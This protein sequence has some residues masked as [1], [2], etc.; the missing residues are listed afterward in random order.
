MQTGASIKELY[1]PLVHSH[2]KSAMS[3][4]FLQ[5]TDLTFYI[6]LFPPLL[7]GDCFSDDSAVK[8]LPVTQEILVRSLGGEDPL[9]EEMATHSNILAWK[10]PWRD[11]VESMGLQRVGHA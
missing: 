10:I 4:N 8:N 1:H 6:S 7:R 5:F 2:L 11:G 9:E 3:E